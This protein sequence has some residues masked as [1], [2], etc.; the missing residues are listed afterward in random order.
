M[1][2][3]KSYN[4]QEDGKSYF[5]PY[6]PWATQAVLPN[7]VEVTDPARALFELAISKPLCPAPYGLAFKIPGEQYASYCTAYLRSTPGGGGWEGSGVLLSMHNS[8]KPR[9]FTFALCLHEKTE[10]GHSPNHN[11]GWHPGHCALCGM[12]M[13]VDSGD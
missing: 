6:T 3:R 1:P 10:D 11:R 8:L 4:F 7:L 13:S 9:V 2:S 12:D 5:Y